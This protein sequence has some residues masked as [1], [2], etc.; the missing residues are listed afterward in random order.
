[1]KTPD[2]FSFIPLHKHPYYQ[3]QARVVSVRAGGFSDCRGVTLMEL[4]TV[5]AILA[6]LAGLGGIG[7]LRGMP[8]RRLMSASRSLYCGL[9][10]AQAQAVA[11]GERVAVSFSPETDMFSMTDS[12]G[13]LLSRIQFPGYI[14]LY[15]I[16]GDGKTENQYFFN[17]L[18]IKTGVS[19]SVCIRYQKPGYDL[20]RVQVRSTGSM[21]IERSCDNG[22]TWR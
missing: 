12:A 18:G 13:H 6:V 22:K 17:P 21:I 3:R 16:T 1:M 20:R 10:Q 2:G 4:L 5:L 7:I 8:E 9:R 19:G 15:D 11:R 14:D